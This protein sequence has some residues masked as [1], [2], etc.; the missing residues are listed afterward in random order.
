MG[1]SLYRQGKSKT[2]WYSGNFNV[3]NLQLKCFFV[4]KSERLLEGV[5][6]VTKFTLR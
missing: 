2:S 6:E 3:T 1:F 5:R 4:F